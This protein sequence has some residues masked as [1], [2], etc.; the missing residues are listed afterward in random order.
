M[1]GPA[2]A[3]QLYWGFWG[4]RGGGGASAQQEHEQIKSQFIHFFGRKEQHE[5][6]HSN[7][8]INK[9][10]LYRAIVEKYHTGNGHHT[11][12]KRLTWI[13]K[14]N[15]IK[16]K[17]RNSNYLKVTWVR[18]RCLCAEHHLVFFSISFTDEGGSGVLLVNGVIP[19]YLDDWRLAPD[20]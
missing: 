1:S 7:A 10:V 8:T 2:S 6:K 9:N 16:K 15:Q 19:E 13:I 11:V 3:P 12:R 17:S 18:L 4:G 14:S 20:R 5:E